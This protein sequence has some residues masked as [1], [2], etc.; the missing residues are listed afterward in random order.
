MQMFTGIS[1]ASGLAIGTV[2][3]PDR[4]NLGIRRQMK[5]PEE[6]KRRFDAANL[7]A[8]DEL[9]MLR[10]QTEGDD[11]DII[12]FQI[13]ILSDNGYVQEVY[14]YIDAG[15]G[16]AASVGRAS[17]IFE[18]KMKNI[19]DDYFSER[20]IDIK[21]ACRRV[22]D[23][24]DDAPRDRLS[25][26]S[27]S[28]ILADEL[29]PSD[30]VSMDR[31]MLLGVVT[32]KGSKQGH[33]SIIARTMGIPAVVRV[34][35]DIDTVKDGDQIAV[36]G[37]TGEIFLYPSD[38]VRLRFAHRI[39]SIAINKEKLSRTLSGPAVSKNNIKI[40]LY[41]NCSTP[42]DISNAL[43]TGAT[44]IGLLRTEGLYMGK[45]LPDFGEQL[46]FYSECVKAARG[47]SLTIRTMDIGA[48][49]FSRN[50]SVMDEP[51]PALGVRGIRMSLLRRDIFRDQLT[52][53]IRASQYGKINI[54]FPMIATVSD[55]NEAME[56][57]N[58]VKY[59]LDQ[60]GVPYSKSLKFGAM[61]ETPAAALCSTELA[62]YADFF[63]IGTNDLTQYTHAADRENPLV[64]S[65]FLTASTAVL[66]LIDMAVKA[67][68]QENIPVS[69]CGE[70]AAQPEIAM[71]YL[72]LS[73]NTLSMASPFI[74]EVR[75][76]ISN[77]TISLI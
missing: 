3:V 23:I 20:S 21:D 31:S 13:A 46:R 71:R 76:Y 17:N 12:E 58:K 66:R 59:D 53:I 37:N 54:M 18:K 44:G 64:D 43:A 32:V 30:M 6:E 35:I 49:K 52:A 10:D 51:N 19:G 27:P 75:E 67:A 2:R 16:A 60:E 68:K 28:I 11:R 63:S 56:I 8:K 62:R 26:K 14:K 38:G 34:P 15:A 7:L 36:D 45:T 40:N 1:A 47:Y 9:V 48:D 41:A 70:S 4:G 25:L 5:L 74:G 55:F 65:Y 57:V 73:V 61:I 69:V 39:K 29:T 77:N 22:V 42:Q 33:A 72:E 50:I 24:L